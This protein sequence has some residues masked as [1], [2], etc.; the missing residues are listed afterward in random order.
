MPE[1]SKLA[2]L[3][4]IK[5]KKDVLFGK[6]SSELDNHMK[7]AAWEAVLDKAKSLQLVTEKRDSTYVRDKLYGLWKSRALVRISC[8]LFV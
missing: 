6:F 8:S 7:H 3:N 4:L 2:L 5:E 1:E